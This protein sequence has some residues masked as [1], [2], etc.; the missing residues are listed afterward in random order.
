MSSLV[1]NID[2]LP[3]VPGAHAGGRPAPAMLKIRP[4]IPAV[5][6]PRNPALQGFSGK[7]SFACVWTFHA[8]C[9]TK[10]FAGGACLS[11][12][13]AALDPTN[14]EFGTAHTVLPDSALTRCRLFDT[15]KLPFLPGS[16]LT[17]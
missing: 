1:I 10:V 2:A 11:E 15:G 8:K 13:T 5:E 7:V 9:I 14:I 12:D 4:S 3:N 6:D 17:H 16:R